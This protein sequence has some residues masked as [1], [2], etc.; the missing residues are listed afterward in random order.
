[1]ASEAVCG[2]CGAK[3]KSLL[4]CSRCKNSFYCD[5]EHQRKHWKQHKVSCGKAGEGADGKAAVGKKKTSK[6]P[7]ESA[8][9]DDHAK[10][11][12]VVEPHK[13]SEKKEGA[14]GE[15][16]PAPQAVDTCGPALPS[17]TDPSPVP[18]GS[19]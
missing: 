5:K 9:S 14:G 16:T 18:G 1:M 2:F 11:E 12:A 15:T 13:R 10:P 8:G 3:G 4:R 17:P 19:A 6:T 7:S